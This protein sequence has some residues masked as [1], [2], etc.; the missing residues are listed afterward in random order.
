MNQRQPKRVMPSSE[1]YVGFLM[2][3]FFLL[4]ILTFFMWV[5]KGI[6]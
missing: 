5:W 3:I 4:A 6:F 1:E 2:F